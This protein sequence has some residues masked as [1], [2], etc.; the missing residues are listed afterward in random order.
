MY[1]CNVCVITGTVCSEGEGEGED[2]E[3]LSKMAEAEEGSALHMLVSGKNFDEV[4]L[5]AAHCLEWSGTWYAVCPTVQKSCNSHCFL[6]VTDF[7]PSFLMSP[8]PP[9]PCRLSPG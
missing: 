7:S 4:C 1:I 5:Q 8:P 2:G 6:T 3:E 9:L